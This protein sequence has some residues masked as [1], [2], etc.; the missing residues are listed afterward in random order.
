MTLP[1]IIALTL[2]M[3]TKMTPAK[4]ILTQDVT[5]NSTVNRAPHRGR[6]ALQRRVQRTEIMRAS[7]PVVVRL[8]N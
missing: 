8:K 4:I 6:A 2:I 1:T 5:A 7:A 3:L